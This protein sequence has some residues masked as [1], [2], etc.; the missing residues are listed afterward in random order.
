MTLKDKIIQIEKEKEILLQR[1]Y[2][3]SDGKTD[4]SDEKEDE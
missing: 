3:L 2:N 4:R 1:I